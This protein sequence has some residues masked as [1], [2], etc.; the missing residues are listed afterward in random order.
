[1]PRRDYMTV[2]DLIH[3]QVNGKLVIQPTERGRLAR[4]FRKGTLHPHWP[5]GWVFASEDDGSPIQ[6]ARVREHI[7]GT[8][9]EG[10]RYLELCRTLGLTV[11]A[12]DCSVP[13]ACGRKNWVPDDS[14]EGGHWDYYP[15]EYDDCRSDLC[16][17]E[18][19]AAMV[20]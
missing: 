7:H 17:P 10:R 12:R 6:D 15:T 4:L 14:A 11:M 19:L 20:K 1:M 2:P 8:C 13:F 16:E 5:T 9:Q 18:E 3:H